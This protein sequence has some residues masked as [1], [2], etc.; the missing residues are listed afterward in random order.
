VTNH[1]LI[2]NLFVLC[3]VLNSCAII[4]ISEKKQA[5]PTIHYTQESPV[6]VVH[7]FMLELDSN[8]AKGAVVLLA[9]P[10]GE[11]LSAERKIELYPE[12]QRLKRILKFEPITLV[13]SDT[14]NTERISVLMEIDYYKNY[15]F[16]TQKINNM[17]YI[18]EYSMP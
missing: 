5:P 10:N 13:K 16:T 11:V 17:W 15:K 2:V 12:M 8:N 4:D 9:N 14:I 6:G 18:T 3:L 1:K 7:L